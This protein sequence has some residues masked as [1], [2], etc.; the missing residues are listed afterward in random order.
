[1]S[2]I[3]INTAP[4]QSIQV[5]GV[6]ASQKARTRHG[7]STAAA[8]RAA[9]QSAMPKQS[10]TG[11][12]AA[13]HARTTDAMGPAVLPDAVKNFTDNMKQ[14]QRLATRNRFHP[15]VTRSTDVSI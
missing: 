5:D 12:Q 9:I 10:V 13:R 15:A 2:S 1:M 7:L 3:K 6:Q 8:P 14:M 4:I 11:E